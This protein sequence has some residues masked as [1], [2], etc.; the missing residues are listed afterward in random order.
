M[1]SEMCIRDSPSFVSIEGTAKKPAIADVA[2]D[3]LL[4]AAPVLPSLDDPWDLMITGV[5]GTGV[6]TVAALVTMAAHL[7]GKGSTVLDFTGFAQ[8]FGPVISYVRI[9]NSPCAIN[10]V[11]IDGASADALLGCDI[12]V[13]SSPKA[14]GSYRTGMKLAL[15]M[16]EMP[17]GDIVQRRDA[18]LQV[19]SRL[20]AIARKAGTESPH[21][22]NANQLAERVFGDT[23]F[24]NMIMLG[25]A[26]QLGLVPV[27]EAALM[28]AIELNGVALDKNRKA[29]VI[30]RIAADNLP[31][32]QQRLNATNA[33]ATVNESVEE[34]IE[35][36]S[37]YLVDYQ[38]ARYAAR[39]RKA[40]TTFRSSLGAISTDHSDQ[41]VGN[42]AKYLYKLMAYK[43]EYEVARLQT[44]AVFSAKLDEQFEAGYQVSYHLAPPLLSFAKDWRGRPKKRQL[45]AWLRYPMAAL[46]KSKR[47]RATPLDVFGYTA[48]RRLERSLIGWY[49]SLLDQCSKSVNNEN[50]ATWQSLL[51]MPD[52]IRGYGSV[53][54]ESIGIVKRKVEQALLKI[55]S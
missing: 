10:Q 24:S 41:L 16:A 36:H 7:E 14:S 3:D 26:W 23:V 47:L 55:D 13:S 40:V 11:R 30:G 20:A 45:G 39:Y 38:S 33:S 17:T 8:K 29:I 19:D 25:Y 42:A 6:V 50:V 15:N 46:A 49:Q 5:G 52:G 22:I 53:K 54:E 35:R 48:E 2:L 34:C 31:E 37:G 12:V 28:Q 27:T 32:L 43:D 9:G 44:S 51:A 1:G 4:P 21:H 18:S